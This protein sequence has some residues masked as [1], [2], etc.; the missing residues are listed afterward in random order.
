MRYRE[1][2]AP[3]RREPD[4]WLTRLGLP[5]AIVAAALAIMAALDV[6]ARRGETPDPA[7]ASSQAAQQ[8]N[9]QAQQP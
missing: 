8:R 2:Y 7:A 3:A 4:R 1:G 5:L 6:D 9:E